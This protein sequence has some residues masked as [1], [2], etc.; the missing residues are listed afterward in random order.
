ML[1]TGAESKNIF[2]AALHL[3]P[4]KYLCDGGRAARVAAAGRKYRS[5]NRGRE[6]RG[7]VVKRQ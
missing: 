2:L 7:E 5:W 3:S 6:K 1:S 4:N